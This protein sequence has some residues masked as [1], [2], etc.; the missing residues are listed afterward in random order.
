MQAAKQTGRA[1]LRTCGSLFGAALLFFVALMPD[2]GTALDPVAQ[3]QAS[4]RAMAESLRTLAWMFEGRLAYDR[5]KAVAAATA[6]R[7]LSGERLSRE[8]AG[9]ALGAPSRA[10]VGIAQDSAEFAALA[11]HLQDVAAAFAQSAAAGPTTMTAAMRMGSSGA[12][13]NPL[14]GKRRSAEEPNLSKI[15]MEHLL[16]LMMA[17]CGSCHATFRAN[18][19]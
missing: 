6:I 16:H 1:R 4:M 7:D 18:K 11:L 17:D 5:E 14:L 8:F 13:G 12:M 19:E 15:P 2:A 9:T 10:K 3:R